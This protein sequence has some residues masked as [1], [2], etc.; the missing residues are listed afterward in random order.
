M[1]G[2]LL[3]AGSVCYVGLRTTLLQQKSKSVVDTL[4]SANVPVAN[5]P[6]A[7]KS[8]GFTVDNVDQVHRSI[9]PSTVAPT[10]SATVN[11]APVGGVKN[12]KEQT[13]S[14]RKA[15]ANHFLATSSAAMG[16]SVLGR[17]LY[18][19]L[20]LLSV[21][22]MLYSWFPLVRYGA[23]G[24]K[25]RRV[26]VG[27]VDA[28]LVT[29]LTVTGNFVLASLTVWTLMVAERILVSTEGDS[30]AKLVNL[31]GEKP[32]TV[33]VRKDGVDVEIPFE[34]LEVG[35]IVV[36]GAGE[37][38]P[39]DGTIVTGFATV[40]QRALT[41]EAQP[42]EK[43][44]GDPAYASTIV[45]SGELILRVEK[46][47]N[48]TVAAQIGQIL[49]QTADFRTSVRLRGRKVAD[50]YALPTIAI[51]AVAWPLL[52][53]SSAVAALV[54]S[55]GYNLR[56]ISPISVLNFLQ[57]T[58]RNG[59]LIK[60][61]RSLEMLKQVDTVVFDK[62][63]TLTIEQPHVG[64]IY[65]CNTAND[66][67]SNKPL[68][69]DELLTLAAA[70]EIKQSHPIAKA[71]LAEAEKRE[72]SLPKIN[73]AAYELGY[74]IKVKIDGKTIRVG[75][76]RFMQM[77]NVEIPTE[78]VAIQE[79]C[80]DQG[81][82][83]V[84][85]AVDHEL[86]GAIEL[87][88]TIRPEVPALISALKARGITLCIISGDHEK[89][90]R[91]MASDLGIDNYFAE[92]LPEGKSE[93]VTTLQNEGRFVCFIGDGIND[94]IALKKANVSISMSGATTVATDTAQIVLMDGELSQLEFLF[95]IADDYDKNMEKNWYSTMVPAVV[96]VG[97]IFFLHFHVLA[98]VMLYNLGLTVG[99]VNAM[100]PLLKFGN[101]ADS[102]VKQIP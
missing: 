83:L 57:V 35:N 62:T 73:D 89:S 46:A 53:I 70:A 36:V 14:E 85:V 86:H 94:S 16:M 43:H 100:S 55:F 1:I 102:D 69:E 18:P 72:L 56:V 31:F 47:G 78:M 25:E 50:D 30:H 52:G 99:L 5:V 74:G 23:D 45:L 84:Y 61:G 97:G 44:E 63:G 11:N 40:D 58:S 41:G 92:V 71:I 98:G 60:D 20:A 66:D 49:D 64:Q 7:N 12:G 95:G 29:G 93:I 82:S 51:A 91:K 24:L 28:L 75:S 26:N 65:L 54:A 101:S 76:L 81:Y 21:P 34:S 15:E 33:W 67:P 8:H 2:W 79:T 48:E 38:I 6:V 90:T 17:L 39:V 77:E 3:V 13:L 9:D 87:L 37:P 80:H 22:A 27:I 4:A 59:V 19:P 88:P 10:D 96:C 32:T 68:A 42:I